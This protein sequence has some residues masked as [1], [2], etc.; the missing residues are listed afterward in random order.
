M[1]PVDDIRI[2]NVRVYGIDETVVASGYP[3]QTDIKEPEE[4]DK[5]LRRLSR[6][7]R[8]RVGTGHDCALKGVIVQADIT[9]PQYWWLQF[10]RYHFADIVSSQ[11]KM[12]RLTEM[13][14][15]SQCNI[16][17]DDRAVKLLKTLIGSYNE[18]INS[19]GKGKFPQEEATLYQRIIANCPMGLMLTARITTN[20]LQLKTMYRQRKTHR[21]IEWRVFC[22]WILDLP[23]F[24]EFTGCGK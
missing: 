20:Y 17:V 14:I 21:L 19:M 6:L 16:Y 13:D 23:H 9:A 5:G 10:G 22:D 3:M 7:G 1:K 12:H 24:R 4:P 15:D 8:A 11:S 2:E 18:W